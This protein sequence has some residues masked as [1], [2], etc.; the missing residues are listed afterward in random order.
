VIGVDELSSCFAEL[1]LESECSSDG[2]VM[3]LGVLRG[4]RTGLMDGILKV[5]SRNVSSNEGR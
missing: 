2:N 4:G 3:L 1:A 5:C